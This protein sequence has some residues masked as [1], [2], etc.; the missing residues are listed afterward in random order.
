MTHPLYK[1]EEL[2]NCIDY[3]CSKLDKA[4]YNSEQYNEARMELNYY[5]NLL[6]Q[7]VKK[8]INKK[9]TAAKSKKH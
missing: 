7:A 1:E 8:R 9:A 4:S 3:W 5:K 6:Q 2:L